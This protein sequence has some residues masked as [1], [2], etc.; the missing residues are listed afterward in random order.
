MTINRQSIKEGQ[1]KDVK[2]LS[3]NEVVFSNVVFVGIGRGFKLNFCLNGKDYKL[4]KSN[5]TDRVFIKESAALRFV[6]DVM[7]TSDVRFD[8][9]N[10]NQNLVYDYY[11]E[12]K[13]GLSY[14]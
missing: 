5:G 3:N 2:T 7:N 14:E 12:K 13:K 8:I 1:L 4:V 10:W 9:S 6:A 11:R